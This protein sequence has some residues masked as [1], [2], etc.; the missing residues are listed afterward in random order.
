[1]PPPLALENKALDDEGAPCDAAVAV[2]SD[3]ATW[4]GGR[5][6]ERGGR[7]REGGGREGGGEGEGGEG[8]REGGHLQVNQVAA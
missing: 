6:G 4:C 7:G 8:G 1:V 5:E 3:D 2:T